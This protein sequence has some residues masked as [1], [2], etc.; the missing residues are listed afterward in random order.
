ME[1]P[2]TA[3][4]IALIVHLLLFAYWLGGDVGVFYS[5]RFVVD[6]TR[7]REARL[8]AARIMLGLDVIPRVC[9]SLTLTVGGLLN[10]FYGVHHPAWELAALL[11]LGPCWLAVVLYLHFREGTAAAQRLQHLD[12][13]FR[14]FLIA[15]VGA[16]VAHSL[17]TGRLDAQPWIAAKLLVFAFL[18]FCGLMIRLRLP[19]FMAG[20]RALAA[21]RVTPESERGM[22]ASLT[23]MRPW[24]LAIWAGVLAAAVLGVVKPWGSG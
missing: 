4:A 11:A 24:V 6:A 15:A 22:Q 8:A 2:T 5:S 10:E 21:D 18:V 9:L 12:V 23:R 3:H 7:P 1:S 14:W 17:A 19:P 20:I 16:S 13:A